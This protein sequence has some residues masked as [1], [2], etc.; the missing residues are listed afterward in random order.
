MEIGHEGSC[1]SNTCMAD[2]KDLYH[3]GASSGPRNRQLVISSHGQYN[4]WDERNHFVDA[5]VAAASKGQKWTQHDWCIRTKEGD[6][7]GTQWWGEQTNFVSVNK[8]YNGALRGY[9]EA[10]VAMD[11][12]DSG[13]CGKVAGALG[14]IA[15][16]V[17][18]IAGGF[19]GFVS[20]LC[21]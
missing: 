20:A 13:W 7:C 6:N 11:G 9:I 14:G 21:S 1:D 8:F 3:T 5:V 16:A 18:P 15:G 17:N 19:F 2:T 10:T 4:G 12:G